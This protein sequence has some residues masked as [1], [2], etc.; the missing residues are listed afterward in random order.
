M[1]AFTDG[2]CLGNPAPCGTGACLY[3]PGYTDPILHKQPVTSYGS[4]LLGELIAMKMVINTIQNQTERR[5]R[6]KNNVDK[7]HIFSDS[8]CAIGHLTLVLEAKTHRASM[9]E[10]KSSIKMLESAGI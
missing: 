3:V 2:S 10:V 7:I 1:I 4:I 5:S 6:E 9:Q 8:Q